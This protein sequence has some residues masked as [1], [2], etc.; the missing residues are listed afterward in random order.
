MDIEERVA[1]PDEE[2]PPDALVMWV[3]YNRLTADHFGFYVLR[4][5]WVHQGSIVKSPKHA[6]DVDLDPLREAL[7]YG[8]VRLPRHPE[9]DL[10]IEEVW[11]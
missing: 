6:C 4:R 1:G 8:V 7:P 11:V 3:I 5:Q 2:P 9:D 10:V